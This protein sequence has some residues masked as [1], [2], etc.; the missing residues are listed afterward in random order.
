MN[1]NACQD[2][3]CSVSLKSWNSYSL[4]PVY[5]SNATVSHPRSDIVPVVKIFEPWSFKMVN[6]REIVASGVA[7]PISLLMLRVAVPLEPI[8]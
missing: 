8:S 6:V 4:K 2:L 7:A 5:G 1:A 3:A